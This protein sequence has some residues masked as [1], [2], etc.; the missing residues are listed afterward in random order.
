M[1]P[2][3]N[4]RKVSEMIVDEIIEQIRVG[5]LKAG[6]RLMNERDLAE[7]LGVSRM[8]LREAL[9]AL[10]QIGILESRHGQGTFV[11]HY[12][13]EK[14]GRTM[15][16]Y[17]L[18]GSAPLFDLID[19]RRL[20]EGEAARQASLNATE[21][22][23]DRIRK[24]MVERERVVEAARQSGRFEDQLKRF[25]ADRAFH[26]AIAVASHNQVFSQFLTVIRETMKIHQ[27]TSGRNLRVTH[28]VSRV[29]R[30]L[31]DAIASRDADRAEAL[32]HEHMDLVKHAMMD[33]IGV[34]GAA[35]PVTKGET[36]P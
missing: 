23:L 10:H 36:S 33:E 16:W 4:K 29:H 7:S 3:I 24:A 28:D 1:S 30:E 34:S 15:Y 14:A 8:P 26:G 32:M 25:E 13:A 20:L 19:T 27:E 35:A 22:D 2:A 18:L 6:Q 5:T 12:D 11:C 21:D 17:T 31:Y 9:H